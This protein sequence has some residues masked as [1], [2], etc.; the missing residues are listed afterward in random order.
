MDEWEIYDTDDDDED[1]D[2]KPTDV[3]IIVQLYNRIK[4]GE[5]FTLDTVLYPQRE[6]EV[7]KKEVV[8]KDEY[9][10]SDEDEGEGRKTPDKQQTTQ[11]EEFDFDSQ[12]G[13]PVKRFTPRRTPS[14]PQVKKVARMDKVFSNIQKYRK[15]DEEQQIKEGKK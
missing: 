6:V 3:N 15:M 10:M 4:Q 7:V 8:V 2:Y 14:R 12:P 9:D 5:I 11:F 1:N 13:A